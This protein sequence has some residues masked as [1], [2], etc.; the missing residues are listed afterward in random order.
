MSFDDLQVQ[1]ARRVLESASTVVVL[2]GAGI[3]TDSG[4][5]DFR[6]PNGVWTKNPKAERTSTLRHYLDD[7]G[8]REIA[9]QTRIF[10]PAWDAAP[11]A[12]HRAIVELERQGRLHTLVTQN[13]D[14]LHQRA[15]TSPGRIVEIH[16][17]MRRAICWGCRDEGPMQPFLD[18]VRAGEADPQCLRCGG[19]VKSATISFGQNLVE[20]DLARALDAAAAGDVLLAVGTSLAVFPIARMVPIALAAN[21]DVVIVNAEPTPYDDAATAVVNGSISAVLP[22]LVERAAQS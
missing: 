20:E 9:W 8:V 1:R 10:S 18:R 6:G 5:P 7:P 13:I 22:A 11:N 14:E 16:G 19:I 17:T 3:S 15:G 2:T 21:V 12:G 4:I